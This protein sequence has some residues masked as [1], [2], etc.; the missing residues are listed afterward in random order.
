MQALS[1]GVTPPLVRQYDS[2]YMFLY[3]T[4]QESRCMWVKL[5]GIVWSHSG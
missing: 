1:I 3:V 4:L 5:N 2:R